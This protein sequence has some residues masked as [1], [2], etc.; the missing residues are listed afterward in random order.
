MGKKPPDGLDV[1][2][3]PDPDP[4]R[5][6]RQEQLQRGGFTPFVAFRLSM[7]E[8][9]WHQAVDMLRAG[10]SENQILDMFLDY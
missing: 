3:E 4:V 1:T 10:A 2:V 9:D 7:T 8:C 5:A 6:W